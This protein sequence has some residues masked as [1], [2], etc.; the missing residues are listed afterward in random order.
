[1]P[2]SVI[3]ALGILKKS[4]AKINVEYGLDEKISNAIV[5][6]ATEV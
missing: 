1:M 3:R 5:E 2:R 6:A 4:I